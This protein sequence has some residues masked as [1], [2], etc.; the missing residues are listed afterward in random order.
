[1]DEERVKQFV[2]NSQNKKGFRK[3]AAKYLYWPTYDRNMV[4]KD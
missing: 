1:M 4:C 2:Y 3:V